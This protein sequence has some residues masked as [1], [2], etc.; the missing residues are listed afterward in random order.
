VGGKRR[1]GRKRRVLEG[2]SQRTLAGWRQP[3]SGPVSSSWV[4][5]DGKRPSSCCE[6]ESDGRL[7]VVDDGGDG[8]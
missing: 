6:R 7:G 2:A 5:I 8:R 1:P 4:R 3:D